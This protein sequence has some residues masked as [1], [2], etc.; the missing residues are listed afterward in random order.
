METYCL[1]FWQ[2]RTWDSSRKS[3]MNKNLYV[4]YTEDVE[5]CRSY[6]WPIMK[7]TMIP[8]SCS[9]LSSFSPIQTH[10]TLSKEEE[11]GNR[12]SKYINNLIVTTLRHPGFS[13]RIT[14]P[15]TTE[16]SVYSNN[17][18]C[19]LSSPTSFSICARGRNCFSFPRS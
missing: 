7:R 6:L 19:L 16:G 8:F 10:G 9:N 2:E 1:L 3:L 14:P 5:H 4:W 12:N 18:K 15:S 17:H 13:N 11:N